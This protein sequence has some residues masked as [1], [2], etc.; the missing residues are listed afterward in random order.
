[1]HRRGLRWSTIRTA[2]LLWVVLLVAGVLASQGSAAP[3]SSSAE[4]PVFNS[5]YADRG[6]RPTHFS[7]LYVIGQLMEND[8][9]NYVRDITWSSWGESEA[10][11]TGKVSL[12]NGTTESSPVTIALGG[13][14]D[15]AGVRAYTKVF[16][17]TC[18]RRSSAQ[19]VAC[20]SK[21]DLSMRYP[22][23]RPHIRELSRNHQSPR[24]RV[25]GRPDDRP[26]GS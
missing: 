24:S 2:S 7:P 5:A 16:A 25:H 12:L 6:I 23:R 14:R 26:P 11:G 22:P 15:C 18:A 10:L 20:R 13:V 8:L 9:N 3:R 1:M 21:R 17:R 19:A 4:A